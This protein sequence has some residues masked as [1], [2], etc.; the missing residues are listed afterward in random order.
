MPCPNSIPKTQLDE[1]KVLSIF[2]RDEI[3]E[4]VKL[5]RNNPEEYKRT[6]KDVA[7]VLKDIA[8]TVDEV[9]K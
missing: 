7:E 6:L 2:K 3:L 9:N 5:K 4:L 8:E 1:D